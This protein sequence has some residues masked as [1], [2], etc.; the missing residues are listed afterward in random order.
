[1]SSHRLINLCYKNSLDG[2]EYLVLVN[3]IMSEG[4]KKKAPVLVYPKKYK[5]GRS[6]FFSKIK[7]RGNINMVCEEY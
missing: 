7:K 5:E 6:T 3:R 1:M 2:I 4:K